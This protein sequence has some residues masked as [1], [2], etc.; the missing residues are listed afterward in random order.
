MKYSTQTLFTVIVMLAS[1]LSTEYVVNVKKVIIMTNYLNN[2][3]ALTLV[4]SISIF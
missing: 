3:L 2:V 4:V 1:T